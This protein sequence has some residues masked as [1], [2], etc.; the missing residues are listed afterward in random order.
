MKW[1]RDVRWLGIL[2]FCFVQW[3]GVRIGEAQ[4]VAHDRYWY[5]L[6][7]WIRPLSGWWSPFKTT[8]RNIR[9]RRIS[10]VRHRR[11]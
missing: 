7:Y 2:N 8:K 5:T 4:Q 6:M 9:Y 1:L 3:F 11:K 10:R